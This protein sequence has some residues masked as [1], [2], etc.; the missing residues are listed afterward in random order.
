MNHFSCV[1]LTSNELEI[2]QRNIINCKKYNCI[3][4]VL[5]VDDYSTDGT[6]R[7]L[8]RNNIQV[9]KNKYVSPNEQR[10]CAYNYV[11]NDWIIFLDADEFLSDTLMQRLCELE[12]DKTTKYLFSRHNIVFKKTL[13][14]GGWFPDY[15]QRLV[16]KNVVSYS[17]SKSL[18]EP[19]FHYSHNTVREWRR[20]YT[21]ATAVLAQKDILERYKRKCSLSD[22][23]SMLVKEKGYKDGWIGIITI[24]YLYFFEW[25]VYIKRIQYRRFKLL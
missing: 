10:C 6:E 8:N 4:E 24:I 22:V 20:K 13:Y 3:D 17:A 5:V 2:V 18:D 15:Q 25:T 14:H 23:Y 1:I 11:K 19:L 21:R 7:Y 9:I 12:L 16:N